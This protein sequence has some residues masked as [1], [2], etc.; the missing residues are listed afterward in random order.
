MIPAG[1]PVFVDTNILLAACDEGRETFTNCVKILSES[2][3]KG[4]H[5]VTSTQVLREFLVV[6][7]RPESANGL[8]LQTTPALENIAEFQRFCALLEPQ[9]SDWPNLTKLIEA[10]RLSGKRIHDANIVAT[11]ISNGINWLITDNPTDFKNLGSVNFLTSTEYSRL[12]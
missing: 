4:F 11:M 9:T 5:P 7:T 3:E 12:L 8:G 6:A 1:E 2:G 10:S